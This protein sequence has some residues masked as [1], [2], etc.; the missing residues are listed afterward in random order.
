MEFLILYSLC[1]VFLK[2]SFKKEG[3]FHNYVNSNIAESKFKIMSDP[4]AIISALS[5]FL[6]IIKNWLYGQARSSHILES[7]QLNN[8]QCVL[9]R[10]AFFTPEMTDLCNI[11]SNRKWEN[12]SLNWYRNQGGFQ[13]LTGTKW[14]QDGFN[15]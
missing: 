11:N 15:T 4:D 7:N 5:R 2:V 10:G 12:F 3:G 13:K 8:I 9:P 14:G 6:N 1:T